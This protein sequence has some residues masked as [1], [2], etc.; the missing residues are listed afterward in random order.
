[1]AIDT[2]GKRRSTVA[3]LPVPD[4]TIGTQDRPH[5]CWIYSGL[6][7]AV[8][9]RVIMGTVYVNVTPTGDVEANITPAGDVDANITPTGDVEIPI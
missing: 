2:E 1:M 4:G 6:V 7:I 9:A 5:V 3:V 8:A